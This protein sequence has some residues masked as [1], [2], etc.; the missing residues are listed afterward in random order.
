MRKILTCLIAGATLL[1]S[2]GLRAQNIT[3][4]F[5]SIGDSLQVRLQKRT[6]VY[7]TLKLDKVMKRGKALDFYFTRE[8]SDYPWREADIKWLRGQIRSLMPDAY[9][10]REVGEIFGNK[11]NVTSLAMPAP[12]NNGKASDYAFKVDDPRRTPMVRDLDGTAWK[13]GLYGRH[14]ALWQSHGRYFEA[15]TDRWEW[16]RAPLH[17]TV[18]DMYTQSYVLPFLMPMLENAGAYVLTPRERDTC[19]EEV[20]CD[21]DPSFSDRSE[22]MRRSGSWQEKGSWSDAGQGFADPK[23]CYYEYDNPFTM[24]TARKAEMSPNSKATASIRWTAPLSEGTRCALYVSYKTLPESASA[25]RYTVRH[26]GGTNHFAVNQRMG[27]GMWVYLGTFEFGKGSYVELDNAVLPGE[28]AIKGSVVTADAVRFGGGRGKIARGLPD[29]DQAG[30]TCSGL[31]CFAEGAL[32]SMQWSGM[33]M[34][35]L[36]EWPNDYTKDYAGRGAWVGHLSGG[37]DV[38]PRKEGKGIPFDLSFAFHTD[39]GL[40]PN[41]SIVGTLSIYTRLDDDRSEKLP[42]GES[43]MNNRALADMVQSQIVADIRDGYEPLWSRRQLWDR[44]YSESRTPTVPAMLLELLSHQN[45]SDMKYGLDPTFRFTV[46]RAIYKGMLKFLSN[47]YGVPYVVQPLPVKDFA[48]VL[49][50]NGKVRLSWAPSGD[51]LEPT[52][53]PTGYILYTRIGDGSFDNGVVLKGV[54]TEDGRAWF[55]VPLIKG[56]VNSWKIAAYNDGGKSFPS[57][58]L[59]AGLPDGA[60][61]EVLVVNNFTRLSA[62]SRVDTPSYAGFTDAVDGGVAWGD[63]INFIGEVYNFRRTSPWTDDDNPGFGGSYTDKAG[64]L[65]P[66]N[67]FDY[68]AV[69]GKALLENGYA[70]SSVSSSALP[71]LETGRYFA[72]DLICGKQVTASVGRDAFRVSRQQGLFSC[73]AAEHPESASM[74]SG[75]YRV[76]PAELRQ[77]VSTFAEGGG[78]VLVSG[79][80]IAT[81]FADAVYEHAPDSAYRHNAAAF[82]KK[83]LGYSWMTNFATRAESLENRPGKA[84]ELPSGLSYRHFWRPSPEGYFV[85]NP[86]GLVPSSGAEDLLRYSDTGVIAATAVTTPTHKA[87]AFGFPL[88]TLR[89]GQISCVIGA[90]MGYFEK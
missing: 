68:P 76:F 16:Q 37:S 86:D 23:P 47:R 2:A 32:Y 28:K 11:C 55:D 65:L 12:G 35:L 75:R 54:K 17:R 7:S 44:S 34:S 41:D 62:P 42:N 74:E 39:A 69:H 61:K 18:E 1:C 51:P 31:P 48:A 73:P 10:D 40:T 56:V 71:L 60:T 6:S 26:R 20:I 38:N 43:R 78:N 49:G 22:G 15:K 81:D 66:G 72:M 79:A 58:I 19:P 52:A 57:E 63:E 64:F 89:D 50:K 14:I 33:D 24:G 83:V 77:A 13:K 21:N 3:P 5:I 59:S 29:T 84:L 88:E 36:D 45:F 9:R 25:V 53:R 87:A 90:V 67:T 82:A 8:F 27:G 85:E 4:D 46:S 80:Y 30:W 70:F